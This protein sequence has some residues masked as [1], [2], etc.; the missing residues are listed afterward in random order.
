[1]PLCLGG[2]RIGKGLKPE[3]APIYQSQSNK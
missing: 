1:V 3:K 2:L